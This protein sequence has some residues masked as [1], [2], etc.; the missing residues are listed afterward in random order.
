MNGTKE[1]IFLVHPPSKPQYKQF[2]GASYF[3][4][5]SDNLPYN[6]TF[7]LWGSLDKWRNVLRWVLSI[8]KLFQAEDKAPGSNH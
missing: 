2:I 1:F 8:Y 4:A 6:I 5:H 7:Y 3:E